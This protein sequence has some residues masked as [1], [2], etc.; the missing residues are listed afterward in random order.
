MGGL[1]H[2]DDRV[3]LALLSLEHIDLGSLT[4]GVP[5]LSHCDS[6]D[7]TAIYQALGDDLQSAVAA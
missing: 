2:G 6:L 4:T 5:K 3:T 7:Y 1:G